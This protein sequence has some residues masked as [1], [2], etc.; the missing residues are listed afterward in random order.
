MSGRATRDATF[1]DTKNGGKM[2]WFPFA[3]NDL[4]YPDSKPVFFRVC[5]FGERSKQLADDIRTS[6]PLIVIGKI[7][8]STNN[9][10]EQYQSIFADKIM[11][12]RDFKAEKE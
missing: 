5:I 9:D 2:C 3:H 8:T 11:F 4:S 6:D 12:L 7:V 10:D 1:W